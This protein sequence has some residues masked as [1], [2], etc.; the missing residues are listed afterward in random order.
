MKVCRADLLIFVIMVSLLSGCSS[1]QK[2]DSSK[3]ENV[4]VS[5][6]I[7]KPEKWK[8]IGT[9]LKEGKEF[10]FIIQKGQAVPLRMNALLPMARLQAGNNSLI[11]TQDTYLL[12]SLS[13]MKISPDGQKWAD[14][15]DLKAQKKLFGFSNG[16]FAIGFSGT[17]EKGTEI[18]IEL[19]SK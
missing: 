6:I 10:I 4:S 9:G 11:F 17:K 12:I 18:S 15:S 7:S 16:S 13:R 3:I 19:V 8:D 5:A 2:I 14:L 1:I